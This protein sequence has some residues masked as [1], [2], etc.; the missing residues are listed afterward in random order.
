[1]KQQTVTMLRIRE[2]IL[3]GDLAPG[4]RVR[5]ADLAV[6]LGISRMPVR[7]ALPALA[8]EGLLVISGQRGYSVRAFTPQ[9]SLEALELRAALE[10]LAARALADRGASAELMAGLRACLADGDTIFAKRSIEEGDEFRYAEMND[11]LHHLIL[12]GSGRR[13]LAELAERC[14]AV[15]FIAPLSIVFHRA[16]AAAI[17]Q[18]L[19][20]AHQQHHS[21]VDA[22]EARD[23]ARAEFLFREHAFTQKR[24]MNLDGR[25]SVRLV[26]A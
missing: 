12:D 11:R 22:I 21:I 13:L 10:G 3:Q 4:E 7:Q 18:F 8:Q 25:S 1:M 16:D 20:Y 19:F 26:K 5:E 23:G 15:P 24:S 17:F 2:M 9:E 14:N 6:R